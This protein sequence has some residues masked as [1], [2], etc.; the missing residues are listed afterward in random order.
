M[1]NEKVIDYIRIISKISD[2]YGDKLLLL[3]D[4]YN[5][6]CLLEITQEQAREFLNE[7]MREKDE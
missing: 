5:A 3:M 1:E 7:L 4:K 2:P 6:N